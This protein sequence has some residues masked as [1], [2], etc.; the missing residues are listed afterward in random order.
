[1]AASFIVPDIAHIH[2]T[3]E[4]LLYMSEPP[5][6]IQISFGIDEEEYKFIKFNFCLKMMT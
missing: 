2:S 3:I 4:D 1:M 5:S 6:L